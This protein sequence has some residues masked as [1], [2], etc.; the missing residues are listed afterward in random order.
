M[1]CINCGNELGK[2]VY[3]SQCGFNNGN[4]YKVNKK[5]EYTLE[6]SSSIFPILSILFFWIY[7]LILMFS[8]G[9]LQLEGLNLTYG[10]I[11]F[12]NPA[13]VVLFFINLYFLFNPN[14]KALKII[15]VLYIVLSLFGFNIFGLITGILNLLS[16]KKED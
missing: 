2:G 14:K 7:E 13:I 10:L 6:V 1:Y 16:K 5:D 12:A 11:V 9:F 15:G 3:Y 4:T 8:F